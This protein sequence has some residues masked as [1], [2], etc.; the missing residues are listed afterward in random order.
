M[1]GEFLPRR[2]LFGYGRPGLGAAT[3]GAATLGAATLG[4]A[5]LATAGLAL[6]SGPRG[7][8][9]AG[10]ALESKAGPHPP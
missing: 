4:A 2:R 1:A 9:G 7:E 8:R 3:L 6:R 5:T 10:P